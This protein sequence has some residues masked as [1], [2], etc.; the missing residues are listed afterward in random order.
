MAWV[1]CIF[2]LCA[3]IHYHTHFLLTIITH[4]GGSHG[5]NTLQTHCKHIVNIAYPSL[6]SPAPLKVPENLFWRQ[7]TGFRFTSTKRRLRTSL[8]PILEPVLKLKTRPPKLHNLFQF[9]SPVHP[10]HFMGLLLPLPS[11]ASF[12]DTRSSSIN[13]YL[14]SKFSFYRWHS[15][16]VSCSVT[17]TVIW[18]G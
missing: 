16:F 8:I 9:S 12:C 11:F 7:S 4:V 5:V 13:T 14:G 1:S 2:S 17:C 10:W 15:F 6:T 3:V 18:R